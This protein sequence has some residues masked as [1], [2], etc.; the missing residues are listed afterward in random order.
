MNKRS[1]NEPRDE[2][3]RLR[4]EN[5]RLKQILAE[6]GIQLPDALASQHPPVPCPP[7]HVTDEPARGLSSQEKIAVFRRLF[8]GRADVF[9]IRWES[10]KGRSGYSPACANEWKRG[11]C[12]KPKTKCSECPD[13][14]LLPVTDHVLYDHLT[15]KHTV[16]VEPLWPTSPVVFLTA[17][18]LISRPDW[19]GRQGLHGVLP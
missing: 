7:A 8:R 3:D 14:Q 13:R 16:G 2:L 11:V 4:R 15:G 12:G 18:F 1:G 9:P 10:A 6:H 5:A 17:G 19:R